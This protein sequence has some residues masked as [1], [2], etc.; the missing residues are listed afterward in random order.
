[1][2]RDRQDLP[3][4][5]DFTLGLSQMQAAAN[6]VDGKPN[7]G[8]QLDARRP[9]PKPNEFFKISL[10]KHF[11]SG[12]CPFGENCHFAHGEHELRQ[13]PNKRNQDWEIDK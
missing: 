9:A 2:R 8:N 12:D 4:V 13:F 6:Q 11:L 1:L 7:A 3:L 10:C 5:S